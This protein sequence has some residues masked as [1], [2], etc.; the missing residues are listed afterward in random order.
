MEGYVDDE[1]IPPHLEYSEVFRIKFM[2]PSVQILKLPSKC[3]AEV[4]AYVNSA[5]QVIFVS[6]DLASNRIRASIDVLLTEQKIPRFKVEKGKQVKL[7]THKRIMLF[8]AKNPE[9]AGLLEAVK[10]IGNEGTHNSSLSMSDIL[11]GLEIYSLSLDLL[12]GTG[13]AAVRKKAATI[14]KNKGFKKSPLPF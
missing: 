3:P 1:D 9:V 10:W 8:A 6:P 5:A 2:N 11:E 7:S 14:N 13:T 12:Y 4:K